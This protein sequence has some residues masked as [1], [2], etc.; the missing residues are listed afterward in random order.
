MH[1]IN[2]FKIKVCVVWKS[3]AEIECDVTCTEEIG[4]CACTQP[5]HGYHRYPS[6]LR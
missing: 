3:D 1:G 4:R 2:N 6:P 5:L